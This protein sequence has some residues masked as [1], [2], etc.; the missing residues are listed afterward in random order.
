[1][2]LWNSCTMVPATKAASVHAT[3]GA[4]VRIPSTSSDAPVRSPTAAGPANCR[5]MFSGDALR[6]AISGPMPVSA[7][8]RRPSG[9]LTALKNDS[10]TVILVPRTASL[11]IGKSVP[12]S[13]L[14]AMPTRTRLL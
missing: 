4:S 7:S 10:P 12:Q 14:N 5:R 1:M 11:R 9:T 2:P 6:Q 3:T 13:T 8:R